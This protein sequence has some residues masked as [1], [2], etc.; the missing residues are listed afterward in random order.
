MPRTVDG[1]TLCIPEIE[2]ALHTVG[3]RHIQRCL[4]IIQQ[5]VV[6]PRGTYIIIVVGYTAGIADD[7]AFGKGNAGLYIDI[8][9]PL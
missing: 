5:I 8:I 7:G 6:L 2:A 1:N 4:H 3:V 9:I